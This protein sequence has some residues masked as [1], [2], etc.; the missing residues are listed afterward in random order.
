[1]DGAPANLANITLRWML[2]EIQEL[3]SDIIFDND[4]LD[5]LK[6]PTD[7][8]RRIPNP[9]LGT[10]RTQTTT[11]PQPVQEVIPRWDEADKVD[12]KADIH[13]QLKIHPILWLLQ[14]PSWT[15]KR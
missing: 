9:E 15:G 2:H 3:D 12:I 11:E 10:A 14:I 5:K 7:C 1:M 13:D 8:V 6:I 4:G